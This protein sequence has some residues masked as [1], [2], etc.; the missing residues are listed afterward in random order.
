MNIALFPAFAA[1]AGSAIGGLTSFASAWL[2][3]HHQDRVKRLSRDKTRR[4][5]LYEQI[6]DDRE[7]NHALGSISS[8]EIILLTPQQ[9]LDNSI[10][11]EHRKLLHL[12]LRG[13]ELN[14][15]DQTDQNEAA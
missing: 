13:S 7:D 3:Q 9:R 1:L 15:G 4:Q 11:N 14:H 2:T 8:A 6:I 12:H 5:E 10:N